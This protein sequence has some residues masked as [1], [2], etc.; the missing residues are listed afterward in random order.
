ML[1]SFSRSYLFAVFAMLLLCFSLP[2]NAQSDSCDVHVSGFQAFSTFQAVLDTATDLNNTGEIEICFAPGTYVGK[3][4]ST[5]IRNLTIPGDNFHFIGPD[6]G[7]AFIYNTTRDIHSV[8]LLDIGSARNFSIEKIRLYSTAPY[9]DLLRVGP[10]GEINKAS[11]L[12]FYVYADFGE[13]VNVAGTRD[14]IDANIRDFSDSTFYL[15]A[16]QQAGRSSIHGASGIKT[17]FATVDRISGLTFYSRQRFDQAISISE[18]LVEKIENITF[19]GPGAVIDL[20]RTHASTVSQLSG[21]AGGNWVYMRGRAD[22]SQSLG[23]LSDVDVRLTGHGRVLMVYRSKVLAVRNIKAQGLDTT[24]TGIYIPGAES[25]VGSV[26]EYAFSGMGTGLYLPG[27]SISSI[28]GFSISVTTPHIAAVYLYGAT[29]K[30][31]TL[32]N[33]VISTQSKTAFKLGRDA[34][35]GKQVN[36]TVL[37]P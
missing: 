31:E 37:E 14:T 25:H 16:L 34:S 5:D 27:G 24:T 7:V 20:D 12:Y 19:N 21:T 26:H 11:Q 4:S 36:I 18:G 13:A 8:A 10:G 1:F 35:L 30:I 29:S 15:Y 28:A 22:S 17:R 33:G 23:L 9:G 32:H 3:T 6:V 2:A